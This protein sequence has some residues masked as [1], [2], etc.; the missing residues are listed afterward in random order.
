MSGTSL[1]GIDVAL[2]EFDGQHCHIT[3]THFVAYP[4]DLRAS[5][6]ALHI[7]GEDEL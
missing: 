2:T 7:S 5:L 3:Q 1:D 4:P 6:L